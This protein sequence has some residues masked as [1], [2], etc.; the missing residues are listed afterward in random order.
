MPGTQPIM[1]S[2]IPSIP[3]T[4]IIQGTHSTVHFIP[5]EQHGT[6]TLTQLVQQRTR[7][8]VLLAEMLWLSPLGSTRTFQRLANHQMSLQQ[9]PTI[10]LQYLT[11]VTGP[12]SML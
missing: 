5:C 9:R 10:L 4:W 6:P 1:A 3:A 11:G 12:S 2:S 7:P 8:E